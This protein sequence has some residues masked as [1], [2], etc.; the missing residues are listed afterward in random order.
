MAND[1]IDDNYSRF[2][3]G[4]LERD[5]APRQWMVLHAGMQPGFSENGG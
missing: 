4:I 2:L 3:E 5:S 1:R